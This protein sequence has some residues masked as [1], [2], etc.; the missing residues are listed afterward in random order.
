MI[1]KPLHEIYKSLQFLE[2]VLLVHQSYLKK[3]RLGVLKGA[4]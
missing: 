4:S 1:N 3:L 2:V